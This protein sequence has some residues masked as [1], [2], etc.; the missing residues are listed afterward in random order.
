MF[1]IHGSLVY[2]PIAE[3]T[4]FPNIVV[5]YTRTYSGPLI[6]GF[7]SHISAAPSQSQVTN[8]RMFV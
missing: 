1:Q 3:S 5:S 2:F 8:I 6:H 4:N 7:S